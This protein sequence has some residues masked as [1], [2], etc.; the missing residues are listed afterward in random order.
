MNIKK[1]YILNI[2]HQI[3]LVLIP[4]IVVPYVSRILDPEGIGKYS[5]SCTL[6]SYFIL[7]VALGFV[8]YGKREI[9]KHRNDSYQQSLV[10]W[11]ITICRLVTVLLGLAIN[12][13]LILCGVY[14]K[15]T[16]LMSILLIDIVSILFDVSFFFHGNEEFVKVVVVNIVVKVLSAVS[17]FIFVKEQNDVWIYA[18]LNSLVAFC[19][20]LVMCFFLKKK[21]VS[22]KKSDLKPFR[23]LKSAFILYIPSI[24]IALYYLIN[25][26][27]IG[28]ITQSD[29][30]NGFYAQAE[31]IV[32]KFMVIITCLNIVMIP[33]NS[34]EISRGNLKQVKENN[35]NTIHFIWLLI[36][37]L[38]CGVIFVA[39]NFIPWFLGEDFVQS[40]LLLQLLSISVLFFGVSSVIG[41]QYLLP[42][43]KDR[44]YVL[45]VLFGVAIS[46]IVNIPLI[47]SL[48]ALGAAITTII[49]EFAIM[50]IMLIIVAKEFS[51]KRIFKSL[52][53]PLIATLI[54]SAVICPLSLLLSP[55]ILNTLIIVFSGLIVYLIAIL[56]LRDNLVVNF[57]KGLKAKKAKD[58]NSDTTNLFD[59]ESTQNCR[60]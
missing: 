14:G 12:L 4:L 40:I 20:N 29:A 41:E 56:L 6:N 33:R 51:L 17:V 18:L 21:L 28:F 19:T 25:K 8:L 50:L 11:E 32:R 7:F 39:N 59:K 43:K 44:Q 31:K 13:T 9:A 16:L 36:L 58:L 5:F 48:G 15:Y 49:S 3:I 30:E 24:A 38:I 10:F 34:Y 35:Y 54:M 52:I 37:P 46:L 22:I 60:G 42:N 53:K 57:L 2:V 45:S 23:H 27:L 47:Y 26:S 1:S 55:S